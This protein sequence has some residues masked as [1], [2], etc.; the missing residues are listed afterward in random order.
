MKILIVDDEIYA[1]EAIREMIDWQTL[2]IDEVL[3]AY[4][5][6]QAQKQLS[7]K[8][9]DILLCDIE[10]PQGTGLELV[11]WTREQNMQ[12]V[13]VFLTSHANFSY[14]NQAIRLETFDYILK[15]ADPEELTGVLAKAV[16]R[17]SENLS[18]QNQLKQA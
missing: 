6:R 15:P 13:T 2:G 17:A 4:S 16:Q 10:M 9:V 14:A 11:S 18:R 8:S 7:E 12:L 5:M 3:T 1:V